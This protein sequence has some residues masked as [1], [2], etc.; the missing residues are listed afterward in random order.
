MLV[1]KKKWI[2][3]LATN[4]EQRRTSSTVI[5]SPSSPRNSEFAKLLSPSSPRNSGP[6]ITA[7]SYNGLRCRVVRMVAPLSCEDKG[8]RRDDIFLVGETLEAYVN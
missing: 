8:G 6:A 3:S 4:P 2:S 5:D 1:E 7:S